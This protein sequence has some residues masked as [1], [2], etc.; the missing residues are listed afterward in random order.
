MTPVSR[1]LAIRRPL[2]ATFAVLVVAMSVA[3]VLVGRAAQ[4]DAG[5]ETAAAAAVT[6]AS[7]APATERPRLPGRP[8]RHGRAGDPD[9]QGTAE[10]NG[11]DQCPT[12]TSP[13][14]TTEPPPPPSTRTPSTTERV[15]PEEA[16][17]VL[18]GEIGAAARMVSAGDALAGGL[19]LQRAVQ[20]YGRFADPTVVSPARLMLSAGLAGDFEAAVVAGQDSGIGLR[21][22]RIPDRLVRRAHPVR[23][24]PVPVIA[25]SNPLSERTQAMNGGRQAPVA[26]ARPRRAALHRTRRRAW[27]A[28]MLA[29]AMSALAACGGGGARRGRNGPYDLAGRRVDGAADHGRRASAV[30][31]LDVDAARAV[32]AHLAGAGH[33]THRRSSRRQRGVDRS[34]DDRVGRDLRRR[35]GAPGRR[36][37][38]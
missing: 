20:T 31:A 32:L 13:P 30:P 7:I 4:G 3:V 15:L 16:T 28:A 6:T 35:E 8:R 12:H 2:V 34:G 5:S 14:A 11:A 9:D 22:A 18:C 33:R 29:V 37:R 23:R 38:L 26:A 25:A 19:R 24:R 21:P 36:R 10:G 17:R 27:T 1:K